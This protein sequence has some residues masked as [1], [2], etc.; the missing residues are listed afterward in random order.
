[1]LRI[2]HRWTARE[3]H[4][5]AVP[6]STFDFISVAEL[7]GSLEGDYRE[8]RAALETSAWKAVQV[9]A[10]SIVEAVLIDYLVS[11]AHPA[12]PKKDPL[13][14]DLSEAIG[15]CRAEDAISS[16][17]ADL[18]SVIRSYRNLIHPGRQVRLGEAP[19]SEN[20][21]RIALSVVDLILDEIARIRRQTLGLTAEQLASKVE[22]DPDVLAILKHL[23]AD[24]TPQQL[25]RLL[26]E[27]LPSRYADLQHEEDFVQPVLE[28][29]SKAYRMALDA[30][31][32]D[33][34]RRVAEGF[35]R[36]LREADGDEVSMYSSTFFKATDLEYVPAN[37]QPM[38]RHH[39]LGRVPSA[40]TAD[41]MRTVH[42]IA[43][44]LA[45]EDVPPWLDP[46]VRAVIS[47]DTSNSLRARLQQ[48][49]VE[50]ATD[51]TMEA[52]A[53]V[54]AAIDRRLAE[55]IAHLSGR[56]PAQAK[57]VEALK[58]AIESN[59]PPF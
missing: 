20:S 28:R 13:K 18:C 7:R 42:G 9:L 53:R 34:K 8:M 38:V 2:N 50:D 41:S 54:D 49:L 26:T 59:R 35:V 10:G 24:T 40:H 27:V 32:D 16:R 17:T 58:I 48:L 47:A 22:R 19:P 3:A 55:W 44:Y 37:H 30:A 14:Y 45:P 52:A 11:T 31:S 23:L 1:M 33:L 6:M 46:F 57:L 25:E 4:H 15:V 29:L 12:R 21:A 5:R 51:A 36:V 39:L 43:K 56:N